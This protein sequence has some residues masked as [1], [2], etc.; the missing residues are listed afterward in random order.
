MIEMERPAEAIRI[1]S[2]EPLPN[3][4]ARLIGKHDGVT[5]TVDA[6]ATYV[7]RHQPKEGG[8]FVRFHTGTEVFK[9]ADNFHELFVRSAK[10]T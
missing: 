2:M 3:G 9:S 5:Y 1:D 4:G 7:N 6:S 8:Y 10:R